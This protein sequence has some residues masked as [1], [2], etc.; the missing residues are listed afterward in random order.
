DSGWRKSPL[1]YVAQFH[2]SQIRQR[3]VPLIMKW[4]RGHQGNAGNEAADQAAKRALRRPRGWWSLRLGAMPDQMYFACIG[5]T[6]AP[7]RTGG[8]IKRQE[9]ARAAQ[10]LWR[11]VVAAN[12]N[13]AIT[14]SDLKETLEALNWSATDAGGAWI[15]KN[16]WCRTSMR[17]SNI[18]GFVLGALF[19]LLPVALREWAWY[20]HVYVQSEWSRCPCCHRHTETQ[21]HFFECEEGRLQR[22]PE[23]APE[24]SVTRERRTG[25]QE[26][27]TSPPSQQQSSSAALR[28]RQDRWV[29]VQRL[30][31]EVTSANG[32]AGSTATEHR[33]VPEENEESRGPID[34]WILTVAGE[35]SPYIGIPRPWVFG[36]A[37]AIAAEMCQYGTEGRSW[38]ARAMA[39][40]DELKSVT[41]WS[42]L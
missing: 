32:E 30:R 3:R 24:D 6:V 9:E 36:S 4:V 18:R 19:G 40:K 20:P 21:A 35:R 12:P 17:D 25:G 13:V 8:I 37:T 34:K 11:A 29:L 33:A 10:R 42:R 28:P 27:Q 39:N 7:Y 31:L 16:S 22:G 38:I 15:R 5:N 26:S 14:E 23:V 1:A 41:R 2:V